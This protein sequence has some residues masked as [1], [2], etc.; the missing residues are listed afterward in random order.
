M[1]RLA[2]GIAG[3]DTLL[4]GGVF[5]GGIYIIQGA[6]GAGKTIL[7]NQLCFAHAA[8]CGKALYVTLLAENHSRLIG[9]LRSFDFFDDAAVPSRVSY[10]SAFKILEDDGLKGLVETLRREIRSTKATLLVLEGLVSAEETASSPRELKKFINE[11][12]TQAGVTNC[13][14]FLLTSAYMS[15]RMVSAEHTMVDG[16]VE[17]RSR[18]VGRRSEREL[19][20]QKFRGGPMLRGIHSFRISDA[21][22]EIHPRIEALYARPSLPPKFD[23]KQ[24]ST[25]IAGLDALLDGGPARHSGTLLMG[26]AG[27]GKTTFGLHFLGPEP[28]LCLSF[29]ETGDALRDKAEK[30]NLPAK[31]RFAAGELEV[32]WQPVTEGNVDELCHRLLDTVRTRGAK[33]LFIDGMD[34]FQKVA[35]EP[36]RVGP[37]LTALMNQLRAMSVTT[38]ATAETDIAGI[39]PGQPLAGLAVRDLSPVADNIVVMRTAAAGGTLHRLLTVLKARESRTD[40]RFRRFDIGSDGVFIEADPENAAVVMAGNS[41]TL[42]PLGSAGG[43]PDELGRGG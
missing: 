33:R 21:G 35:G 15:Q 38:L 7:A 39:I 34:G 36:E 31:D 30:M 41:A 3:L 6:P 18:P 19:E 14:I 5:K 29:S 2:T 43:V 27:I 17:L 12:Q 37:L 40:L 11:L 25:G 4:G 20:I 26:P 8:T 13:T 22:I 16:L 32:L 10:I 23:G 1:D 42:Q 24:T 9:H 28:G